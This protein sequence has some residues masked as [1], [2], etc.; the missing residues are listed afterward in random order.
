MEGEWIT[1]MMRREG[2]ERNWGKSAEESE[3][4]LTVEDIIREFQ[5]IQILKELVS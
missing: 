4:I 2:Q 1:K 5:V 3:K